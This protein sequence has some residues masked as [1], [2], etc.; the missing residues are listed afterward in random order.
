MH[1]YIYI[2]IPCTAELVAYIH[3]AGETAGDERVW[4]VP[5]GFRE[6]LIDILKPVLSVRQNEG[7]SSKQRVMVLPFKSAVF[8]KLPLQQVL[9]DSSL[10]AGLPASAATAL[11]NLGSVCLGFCYSKP[12]GLHVCNAA[13]KAKTLQT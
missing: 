10:R 12:L 6:V 7:T 4:V 9:N 8:D 1:I 11:G 5:V 13:G 3:T 2:Y